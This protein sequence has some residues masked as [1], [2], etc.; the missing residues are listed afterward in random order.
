[1]STVDGPGPEKLVAEG[2]CVYFEGVRAVDGVDLTLEPG[3]ILGV[4]G[5]NGAG[6]TTFLNAV[7]GFQR[8]TAG[9]VVLAGNDVTG[10]PPHELVEAGVARTF[11]DVATFPALTVSENV[12]LGAL[13]AGL[14]RRRARARAQELLEGMRLDGLA[15]L[16]ASALPH[17]EE[18]RVGIARAVALAPKFLLLDEPAA[19]LDAA[20]SVDLAE[21]LV[22]IRDDIGCGILL[23]EHDMRVIFS[24]CEQIQV[25]DYGKT[26]ALGTPEQIATN[27]RVVAAYLGEKGA[28]LAS[29]G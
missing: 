14:S 21:T 26:I 10:R 17:G 24:I 19:G 12:E 2:V 3:R 9:R 18:R 5:P 1:M 20:E 8:L 4:I 11:Q 25:L 6:K 29:A 23:V 28:G 22:R 15:R 27:K 13:G 16:S 7:S